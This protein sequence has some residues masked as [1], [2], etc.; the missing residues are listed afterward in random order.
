M[1]CRNYV[2]A[3]GSV[4]GAIFESTNVP[5]RNSSHELAY[6]A[7]VAL[8]GASVNMFHILGNTNSR[9]ETKIGCFETDNLS[10]SEI[11]L[12]NR[13]SEAFDIFDEITSSLLKAHE[14]HYH[15][16]SIAKRFLQHGG[17]VQIRGPQKKIEYGKVSHHYSHMGIKT[18]NGVQASGFENLYAVGDAASTCFWTNYQVR[19]PGIALT[20][21]LVTARLAALEI[22][23][24]DDAPK[25]ATQCDEIKSSIVPPVENADAFSQLRKINSQSLLGIEFKLQDHAQTVSEWI[26]R[27][28]NLRLMEGTSPLMEIS[29]KIAR[30]YAAEE[31]PQEPVEIVKS[32]FC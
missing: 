9:G 27:L 13:E 15:F 19:L 4:G 7:G 32:A 16:A 31:R 14:A 8:V 6:E 17:L 26:N 29:E 23:K 18:A 2:L 28:D 20:N 30:L 1:Q 10:G 25:N 12:Y 3:G 21:C 11:Y 24:T 5:I 22:N